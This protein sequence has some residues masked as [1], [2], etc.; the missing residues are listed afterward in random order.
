MAKCCVT[1]NIHTDNH[2]PMT[3]FHIF[4]TF[5]LKSSFL[6]FTVAKIGRYTDT[7]NIFQYEKVFLGLYFDLRQ[8][9]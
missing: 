8:C 3:V 7:Y 6:S 9:P 2:N 1:S 4:A 5:I